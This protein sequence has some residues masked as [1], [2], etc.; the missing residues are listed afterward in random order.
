MLPRTVI[1]G[2][3]KIVFPRCEDLPKEKLGFEKGT[4]TKTTCEK[5]KGKGKDHQTCQFTFAFIEEV[6]RCAAL[7]SRAVNWRCSSSGL[8]QVELF[9]VWAVI[10]TQEMILVEYVIEQLTKQGG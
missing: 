2:Q 10:R 9:R 5:G 7:V 3:R 1:L 8:Y 4:N 6:P